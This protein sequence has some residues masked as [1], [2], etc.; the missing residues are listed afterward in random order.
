MKWVYRALVVA[1]ILAVSVV[2]LAYGTALRGERPV[3]FQMTRAID[4]DGK[5]FAVG[6]WYPTESHPWPTAQIGAV[7]MDVAQDAPVAGRG[8][9]LV[10]ISHGNGGGLQG[11]ADLALALAGAGYVV[12][13]PMHTGDNFLDQSAV[14]SVNLF[15][16]RNRQLRT[17][18]DHMLTKWPGN[19]TVDPEKVGVFGFSAGGFT[20]LT[21]IGAQPDMRL[22]AAHCART[23][24]FACDVLRHFNS[25]LVEAGAPVGDPMQASP[26]IKAAVVAAPGLGFTMGPAALAAV[27][28]PVQLWSG[29]KD[30]KVP[31]ATNARIVAEAL[32]QR[33][34]FHQAPGAGH[35]SF[36]VPCGLMRPAD[37]CTDP[38]GFDRK[39][40]HESMNAEVVKFFDKVLEH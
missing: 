37:I 20:V 17:T 6:V 13:A 35:E 30:D 22:I 10:V 40:F 5:S 33:V 29:E 26:E 3:G 16:G 32:G 9:P 31:F 19:G 2:V 23:P 7:L 12:A 25:P 38:E 27:Q 4:A 1:I 21:A 14:G 15:S 8:L 39:A 28:V 24:E 36:L 11:H 18:I 34:E